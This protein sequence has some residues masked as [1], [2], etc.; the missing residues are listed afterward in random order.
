MNGM[1]LTAVISAV[2]HFFSVR[3]LPCPREPEFDVL[4]TLAEGNKRRAASL[5]ESRPVWR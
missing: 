5:S 2:N 4:Q 1:S 3:G